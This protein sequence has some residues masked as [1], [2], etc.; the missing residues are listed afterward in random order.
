MH[1]LP[2]LLPIAL[3]LIAGELRA[4]DQALTV[5]GCRIEADSQCPNANLRG[6]DLTGATMTEESLSA[7]LLTGTVMP[8]GT[9]HE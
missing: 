4:D 3:L 7:A 9:T 8:D 6:A 5:N 1:P 2:L